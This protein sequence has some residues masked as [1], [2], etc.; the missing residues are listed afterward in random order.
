MIMDQACDRLKDSEYTLKREVLTS[1]VLSQTPLST[2]GITSLLDMPNGQTEA[3]LSPF[4]SVINV[5]S[6]SHR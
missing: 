3:D 6:G 4:H 1:I 2:L 5:P